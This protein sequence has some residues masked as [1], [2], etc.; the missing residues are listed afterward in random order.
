MIIPSIRTVIYP[1]TNLAQAK[2]VVGAI[3]GSTPVMDE[4]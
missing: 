3:L 1:V 2:A 4:P